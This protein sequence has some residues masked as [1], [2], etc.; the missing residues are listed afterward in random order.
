MKKSLSFERA[1]WPS[2][3]ALG[4]ALLLALAPFSGSSPACAAMPCAAIVKMPVP[5]RAVFTR[6]P[7]AD[8]SSTNTLCARR[9]SSIRGWD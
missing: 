4:F 8:G 5:L 6:P 7:V 3:L 1:L 2:G 9:A